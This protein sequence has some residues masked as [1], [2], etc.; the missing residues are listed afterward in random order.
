MRISLEILLQAITLAFE[1][2]EV[3]FLPI[4]YFLRTSQEEKILSVLKTQNGIEVSKGPEYNRQ[5]YQLDVFKYW[6]NTL[7]INQILGAHWKV[8]VVYVKFV[9][10]ILETFLSY[11]FRVQLYK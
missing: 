3:Q 5:D 2:L 11:L 6:P 4:Q 9:L 10:K 7:A 1:R 8:N